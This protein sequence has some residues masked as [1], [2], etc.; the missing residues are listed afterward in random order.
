MSPTAKIVVVTGI[1]G[2]G[3]STLV[4]KFL[5]E[6][7]RA[8]E[9]WDWRDCKEESNT[10]HTH[11]VRIIER[12]T[13]GRRRASELA[14]EQIDSVIKLFV[15]L[16]L[17][18]RGVFVFDNI[19]QYVDVYKSTTVDSMHYLIDSILK[20]PTNARFIFT[21][22]PKIAYDD[23]AFLHLEL[24]GLSA[25]ETGLLFTKRGLSIDQRCVDEVHE[26]TQGHPLWT[27]LIAMQ[28]F[29]NRV[30]LEDLLA[31]VRAGKEA[32][33][34]EAMLFE[35]W[36]SLSPKHQKLLRYLAELVRPETE[37]QISRIVENELNYNQFSKAMRQLR[38]L[39]L[40]VIKSPS[41]APDTFELHPLL[42]EFVRRQFTKSER[43]H[44]ISAILVFFEQVIVK[45][46]PALAESSSFD[47][48]QNWTAKIELLIN[49]G[50]LG[51]ALVSLEEAKRPLL[52]NG[53]SEEFVRLASALFANVD[54]NESSSLDQ[55]THDDVFSDLVEVLSQLGRFSD[56][57]TFA[58]RF[59][60][61]VSGAT[62]RYVA[63]CDMRAYSFWSRDA[64]ALAKEWARRG[65]EIKLQGNLDTRHDCG[66]NLA[67][68]QRD[69]GE[70][71]AAL[72]YFLRGATLEDVI[73]VD[74]I[75]MGRGG[76]F[77]GNIAR[78]LFLTGEL[79]SAS[80]CLTKSA[81]L[82]EK[83]TDGL[84]LLN[85]G[86]AAQWLGE[87]WESKDPDIAYLMFRRANSKWETV[88]PPRAAFAK[89]AIERIEPLTSDSLIKCED[90]QI[91]RKYIDWLE[92]SRKFPDR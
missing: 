79:D 34:P 36:K 66:H 57:D 24:H 27:S 19:D 48:L 64:M 25:E 84:R 8:S 63:L 65:V 18:I 78:C 85:Q 51:A 76:A 7:T 5:E 68:A 22:R 55:K 92:A 69:S 16:S 12:I 91:D 72:Q 47:V 1:G 73:S 26:L 82:L 30:K 23:A 9:F 71:D 35:I 61:T 67:L 21:A 2:Q 70:V 28:V 88:S 89:A 54:P 41:N 46:R 32:G 59:E 37:A 31:R 33:L 15:T 62:A 43:S 42:R 10:L 83:E 49:S 17:P 80:T 20:S 45:L 74:S 38:S 56:A 60:Q 14:G 52:A 81:W 29:T 13:N 11:L 53:Y 58:D 40:V 90:W 44:Y 75:D 3:K 6:R 39:D 4:A 50:D 86:W 87:I 77:Y